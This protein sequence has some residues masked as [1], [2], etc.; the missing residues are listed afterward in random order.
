MIEARVSIHRR[1]MKK[2]A[3]ML[4]LLACA[5]ALCLGGCISP[6]LEPPGGGGNR[7]PATNASGA[8]DTVA[9]RAAAGGTT[10]VTSTP[11]TDAATKPG[12][13]PMAG[14]TMPTTAGAPATAPA[15][16]AGTS[17]PSTAATPPP[18]QTGAAGSAA[19][20]GTAG[21]DADAGV[22]TP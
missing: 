12:N 20:M 7:L 8:P 16:A 21:D 1:F 4:S 13:A 14:A 18:A 17:A 19:G 10:A 9:E 6:D 2:T 15:A 3:R 5:G 11:S 22:G